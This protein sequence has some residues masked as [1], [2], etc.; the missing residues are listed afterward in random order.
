M[1]DIKNFEFT[2]IG[3][4]KS[5]SG[6]NDAK[7]TLMSPTG[8]S[9]RSPGSVGHVRKARRRSINDTVNSSRVENDNDTFDETLPELE[10]RKLPQYRRVPESRTS[11]RNSGVAPQEEQNRNDYSD[12][13]SK[14]SNPIKDQEQKI[15]DLE[16]ENT[17]LKVKNVSYRSLLA[18]YSGG[19]SQNNINLVE[20]VSIWK[21][22]YLET[23]DK[24]LKVKQDFESYVQ[25]MEQEKEV[26][27]DQ[28][29]TKEPEVIPIDNPEYI[30][31]R[32][33]ILEELERVTEDFKN[34]RDRYNDLEIKFLSVQNELDE[35][36]QVFESSTARLN[37]EI[38]TLK[39][40]I[41]D[42]DA[43]ISEFKRK[44]GNAE[45]QLAS[46][47]D[48]NG[49]QNQKLLHDLKEREDAI[50]GLKEDIIEKENAIVHY[51]EEIQDKQN[52]LKESESKYAEVQKEF[53]D[54]K[55][56]L[57]K[58][59]FEFED[60]KKSTSRQLQELSVEKI[61]LE[62][63]V[64][65]LRGQ[66]EK[67][68]QQH[69]LTQSENDGLRTKLK[70]IESDLKNEK[71]R[72]EVKIKDLTSDLEDARKNLGEANNTIKELHHEI[73][74][75]A[76]KSKDQLSEEVVE[77]DKE[78]DQLKHRVQ[79]LDEELRTSQAELDKATK[80]REVDHELEIR[81]L[82]NKHELEQESLKRE[83]AHMTDEKERLVDLHRLDIE[84][85]E[86]QIEALR[87]E[88]ENLISREHKESNNIEITLQDKNIQIRRLEADIVQLNE[89]RNDILNKLRSLEQA[90]DRYKSELKDALETISRL[91]VDL[92]NNKSLKDSKDSLIERKYEKLKD[93]FKL[94]KKGYLDEMIKLQSRNRELNSDLQKRMDPSIST[95]ANTTLADKLDY[96][97]LKYNDEVRHNNDLRVINEYLNRVLRASA[98]D[99]RLNLL[100]VENDLNIDIHKENVPLSAPL[101]SSG[102]RPYSSSY[103]REF[104]KYDYRYRQKGKRFKTVALAVLAVIRMYRAA[105]KH[106]W[107]EQRIR[108][109]QRKIIAKEDRITW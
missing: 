105:K 95:S 16:H 101:S 90:K 20:E 2:P 37:E 56:E 12:I 86:R 87:K 32:E 51:K 35:K 80:N 96:Y 73:I 33:H 71:S 34:L 70:H 106:N 50:D 76:T 54:F 19:S 109:L 9:V 104:D 47:D 99:I 14:T 85:W 79:R 49:N 72:T 83:L 4:I 27:T 45:D 31:E 48:Q 30:K 91:R 103:T 64:C 21:T 97:K 88:N 74:K 59:T 102:G 107:N 67:L 81:R 92:E 94:M 69:R 36:K 57:K 8:A 13:L 93:E 23:N 82:Q 3:Y 7:E 75:N 61:Q 11:A 1:S 52:Q 18:N 41:D 28:E 44:L 43:T 38:H 100:K 10:V 63:Q 17:V 68:E 39:S 108:Y 26:N 65:N 25:K 40:T 6:E 5:K 89:E 60:G 15:K 84:T 24:L 55:R 46:I 78:I 53:E 66:I 22:K 77:K 62:K 98:Q 58:Q 42:K 29:K